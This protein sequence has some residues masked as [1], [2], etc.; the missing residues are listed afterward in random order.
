MDVGN[1]ISGFSAFSKPSLYNWKFSVHIVLKP[2]LKDFE[3]NLASMWNE[4]IVVCTFF[5]IAILSVCNEN[6]LF[7][8][9]CSCWVF[10][11]CW[12]IKDSTLTAL[13]FRI[14]NG[15]TGILSPPLSLFIIRLPKACLTSH[16]RM[17]GSRWVTT[18]RGYPGHYIIF[19]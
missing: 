15:S 9:L 10:Q 1:L 11:V 4:H 7:L 13:S 17:S 19:L 8:A 6:W 12:H 16:S 14:L 3:H 5:G 2:S 18:H